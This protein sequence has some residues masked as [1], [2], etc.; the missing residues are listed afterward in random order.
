MRAAA[1]ADFGNG[2]SAVLPWDTHRFINPDLTLTLLRQPAGEW[3]CLDAVTYP[4]PDGIGLA[5]SAVSD[6]DGLVGRATQSLL[7]ESR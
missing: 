4:G 3:L 1:M 5:E 6:R 7:L 2:V